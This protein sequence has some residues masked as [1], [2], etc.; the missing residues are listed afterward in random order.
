MNNEEMLQLLIDAKIKILITTA[1]TLKWMARNGLPQELFDYVVKE[2]D[3][4]IEELEN[5]IND[6]KF[7]MITS[8]V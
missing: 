3:H 6:L 4:N 8:N 1:D 2:S 5:R 7:K